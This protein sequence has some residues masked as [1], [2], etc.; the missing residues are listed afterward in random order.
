MF[1]FHVFA[2][3]LEAGDL[4]LL[5]VIGVLQ[6][7]LNHGC[8]SYC[9]SFSLSLKVFIY[10]RLSNFIFSVKVKQMRKLRAS[11]TTLGVLFDH[12]NEIVEYLAKQLVFDEQLNDEE[13][14]TQKLR[15]FV[16]MKFHIGDEEIGS[17]HYTNFIRLYKDAIIKQIHK[18]QEEALFKPIDHD[19]L[20]ADEA[21]DIYD[22][23]ISWDQFRQN[24]YELLLNRFRRDMMSK[25]SKLQ[26]HTS[27][28]Q[29]RNLK[30]FKDLSMSPL[31]D[32]NDFVN[33]YNEYEQEWNRLHADTPKPP[34]VD[35]F[36]D[37]L[38]K[39]VVEHAD[40]L[41]TL[42]QF[43]RLTSSWNRGRKSI[44]QWYE[45]Y[46]QKFFQQPGTT[47]QYEETPLTN[48][49]GY[50][51]KDKIK[52]L[53]LMK[54]E[55]KS[56]DTSIKASF[57]LKFNIK[58]YQ[59]HKVALK[60]TWI[61]DLMF[62]DKLTYLVAINVNTRYLYVELVN[63]TI[64]ENEFTKTNTK[65]TTSF[66][67]A[68]KRMIDR[69]MNVEH[70]TGDGESAFNSKLANES[71]YQGSTNRGQGPSRNIDFKPVPRQFMG[72]YPKF[73]KKEQKSVK[74]DPLH[75]SLGLIDRVIRT[76][77]DMAYNMK[78]GVITPKVM[79]EIVDQYNHAPHKGLSK[80][81]GFSVTPQMVNDDEELEE[82]IVRRI[83]KANYHIMNQSSFKLNEGTNVKVYNETDKMM[84]RRS[85]IQPG[86]F[87]VI[88]FKNGLY[89]VK[90]TINGK[91][92]T[93]LL[94]RYRLD[95]V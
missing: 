36:M 89:Q 7:S 80:Y 73:M 16:W 84:K 53:Q 47:I 61:I 15:E 25:P 22:D 79:N 34:K 3:R 41:L 71:F 42:D 5:V 62:C 63:D 67:R 33:V 74:T 93:Q 35:T 43:T 92:T 10:H 82:L 77:R 1:F 52:A 9:C 51:S 19:K 78:I 68:L 6:G 27:I 75:G 20:M 85:I 87:T 38:N 46:K 39:H 40:E 56:V 49:I 54:P 94:P 64:N 31:F 18:N 60:N 95:Y 12:A 28:T 37:K 17:S 70:L 32:E 29:A 13:Y 88:G 91:N 58:H 8:S 83:T 59:L 65:R 45:T 30:S 69:G 4:D 86:K 26:N 14:V 55:R 57:P 81:A 2:S 23:D 44:D 24:K 48:F 50:R 21:I 66:I 72:A 90:G 11:P 76:I